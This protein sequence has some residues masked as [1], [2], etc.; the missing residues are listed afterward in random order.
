MQRWYVA[1]V[2]VLAPWM[3]ATAQADSSAVVA[4]PMIAA[5]SPRIERMEASFMRRLP[6]MGIAAVS[7]ATMTQAL[8]VP[9]GWPRTWGGFG[10]RFGDQAGFAV[11]EEGVRLSLGATV[12]WVPDARPCGGRATVQLRAVLP[13]LGCAV[14]ET[15]LLRTPEGRPRPNFPLGVGAVSAAAASTIWRPD[16]DTRAHAISLAATR[17]AIVLGAT[18]VSHLISDWRRDRTKS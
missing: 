11:I 4:P 16:A 3:V 18:V 1:S 8:G 6:A 5:A 15:V 14:R 2:A 12:N 17:V 9:T 10:R 13:R 7:A